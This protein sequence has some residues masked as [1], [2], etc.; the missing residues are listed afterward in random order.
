[1]LAAFFCPLSG[2]G[3]LPSG[4]NWGADASLTPGS[5]RLSRVARYNALQPATW[6]PMLAATIIY[7]GGLDERMSEWTLENTPVFGSVDSAN[8][9][10]DELRDALVAAAF[11]TAVA[12]PSGETPGELASAKAKGLLVEAAAIRATSL[13]TGAIK[14]ASGRTRPNDG[15]DRSFPSGHT[16]RAAA[17]ARLSE[18]NLRAMDLRPSM[19]IVANSLL[20]GGTAGTAWARVEAGVHY[21][22]DVLAGAALGNFIAA[23]IHDGFLGLPLDYADVHRD[24]RYASTTITLGWRF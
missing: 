17:A 8:R 4:G 6:A 21:P 13:T 5:T 20:V 22:S 12:T 14:R 1:M 24:R 9:A 10:S 23:F 19:H 15:N 2:C 16:S 3:T 18:R 11:V 7:A